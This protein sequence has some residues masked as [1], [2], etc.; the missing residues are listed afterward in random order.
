MDFKKIIDKT[1]S[2]Q[3]FIVIGVVL[4]ATVWAFSQKPTISPQ[5]AAQPTQEI[6]YEHDLTERC[7][8]W[9]FYRNRAYKLSQEGDDKGAEKAGRMMNRFYDDLRIYFSEEQISA[10]LARL[11]KSGFKAG[12]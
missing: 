10:E 1:W 11:E 2:I 9:L 6:D 7:K 5:T 8:D 4:I 3:P 12:F